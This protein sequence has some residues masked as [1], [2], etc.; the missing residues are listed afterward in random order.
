MN[1]SEIARKLQTWDGILHIHIILKMTVNSE[2]HI[3]DNGA[4][5]EGAGAVYV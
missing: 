3:L 2:I 1:K 4:C 5:A